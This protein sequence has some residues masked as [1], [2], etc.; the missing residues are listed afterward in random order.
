M[1]AQVIFGG[2][3]TCHHEPDEDDKYF[4]IF[5]GSPNHFGILFCMFHV[6][7]FPSLECN[8]VHK[9]RSQ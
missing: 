6:P 9:G 3:Q 4:Q 2:Q 7:L 1:L 5:Y 8:A